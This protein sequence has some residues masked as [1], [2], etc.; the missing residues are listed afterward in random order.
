MCSIEDIRGGEF[1]WLAV[2]SK[3]QLAI[4]STAG[5]G[6]VPPKVIDRFEEHQALSESID[7]PNWGSA[8]V[9]VDFASVGLFVYDWKLNSGPYHLVAT[10]RYSREVANKLIEVGL[11]L[12]A[13][14][15]FK[16]VFG[17]DKIIDS[18]E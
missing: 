17:D 4:F 7:L 10:A 6:F 3:S 16:G 18:W 8:Q 2:D 13:L 1:D 12:S 14:P 5:K 15:N 9:W 11:K